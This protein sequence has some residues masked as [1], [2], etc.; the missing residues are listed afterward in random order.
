M[1]LC[2]DLTMVWVLVFL[3]MCFFLSD[4]GLGFVN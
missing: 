3:V 2:F 4:R 1:V